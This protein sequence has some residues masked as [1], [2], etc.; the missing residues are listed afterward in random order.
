MIDIIIF[1]SFICF[2]CNPEFIFWDEFVKIVLS[3]VYKIFANIPSN[4]FPINNPYFK[5]GN[6]SILFYIWFFSF[7]YLEFIIKFPEYQ[8]RFLDFLYLIK[9]DSMFL[10]HH[11]FLISQLIYLLRLKGFD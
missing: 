10:L 8:N 2:F 11:L 6:F 5:F 4:I 7:F 3:H 1:F 9:I